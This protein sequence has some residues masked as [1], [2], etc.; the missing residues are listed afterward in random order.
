MTEFKSTQDV[1]AT[2]TPHQTDVLRRRFGMDEAAVN[3]S[4]DPAITPP[5]ND[6]DDGS[7][8]SAPATPP[9]S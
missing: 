3:K 6:E 1:L 9:L 5:P 4:D 8:G 7:G 2:L